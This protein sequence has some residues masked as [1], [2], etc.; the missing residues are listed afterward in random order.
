MVTLGCGNIEREGEAE[1][2]I[3]VCSVYGFCQEPVMVRTFTAWAKLT[4]Y[5]SV[6]CL[7]QSFLLNDKIQEWYM[8]CLIYQSNFSS[9]YA[10]H[11]IQ[12]W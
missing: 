1:L 6:S 7:T 9:L 12:A 8:P 5:G 4:S 11:V 2:E 3:N 10:E